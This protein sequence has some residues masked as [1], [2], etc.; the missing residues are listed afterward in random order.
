[1]LTRG[2][3]AEQ[4]S[5][6]WLLPAVVAVAAYLLMPRRSTRVALAALGVCYLVA[7]VAITLWPF[8]VDLSPDRVLERG[9]WVPGR[10]TLAFLMSDDALQVRLGR[11]DFLA[12]VVLF[13]PAA[14]LFGV[15]TRRGLGLLA[16]VVVL[17]SFAVA[18]EFVQGAT[19]SQRTLDV[20]DAIAGA[21]G[22]VAGGLC[23]AVAGAFARRL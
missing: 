3:E 9:N 10:G 20:D 14:L 22:V 4:L 2:V 18:L 15:A 11:R 7:I 19:I 1:M 8:Q 12:N 21:V 5:I 23:A 16:V 17:I 13:F 6:V